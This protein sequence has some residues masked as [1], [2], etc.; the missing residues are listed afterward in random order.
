VGKN[1][2][3]Q[4]TT[5]FRVHKNRIQ[6]SNQLQWRYCLCEAHWR[7][8][9]RSNG[10]DKMKVKVWCDGSGNNH[11]FMAGGF[12]IYLERGGESK[13]WFGGQYIYTSS[14][15]MELTGCLYALKKIE[16]GE[17]VDLYCDSQYVVNLMAKE[18]LLR[19]EKFKW[20]NGRKNIDLLKQILI[21]IRRIG[22]SKVK[23]NWI[24]GH[25]GNIENEIVDA[26]AK[27]G[28]QKEE[29]II[30]EESEYYLATLKGHKLYHQITK[31]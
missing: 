17:K 6:Q 30:D 9:S 16:K 19:W 3:K 12:G 23:F 13:Q 26:L 21:E 10:K 25:V 28:A 7:I 31:R 2:R 4:K 1:K 8:D 20:N 29:T 27:M 18:W 15:R 11:N 22:Y 14:A 24:R 5:L